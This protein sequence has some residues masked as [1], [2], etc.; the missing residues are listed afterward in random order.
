MEESII[1]EAEKEDQWRENVHKQF[2]PQASQSILH[3]AVYFHDDCMKKWE[4]LA[5]NFRDK[6]TGYCIMTMHCFTLYFFCRAFDQEWRLSFH[7]QPTRLAWPPATFLFLSLQIPPFWHSW[8][9]QG[10]VTSLKMTSR[11]HSNM[12]EVLGTLHMCRKE[13]HQSW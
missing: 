11:M 8:D 6:I 7:I 5:L 9:D 1:I 13:V 4:D 3:T 10:R 12:P 2:T